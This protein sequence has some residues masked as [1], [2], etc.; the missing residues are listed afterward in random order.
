MAKARQGKPVQ[1]DEQRQRA[2]RG[3]RANERGRDGSAAGEGEPGKL[4][5][6][7]GDSH[8]EGQAALF[9]DGHLH[10]TQ[11]RSLMTRIGRQ[12]GNTYLQRIMEQAAERRRGRALVQRQTDAGLPAGVPPTTEE[13]PAPSTQTEIPV[14]LMTSVDFHSLT[15][16]ALRHRHDLLQQT[17]LQLAQSSPDVQLLREQAT[18]ISR[19][20][21]ERQAEARVREELESFLA[22][23][24]SC[25]G[26]C[27]EDSILSSLC[28][29]S[30]N[31][32]SALKYS[33]I[34][35]NAIP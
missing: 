6:P 18:Q 4:P 11:R 7:S 27:S 2:G 15:D 20:L 32:R 19:V 22:G 28:S 17:L 29:K 12:L 5:A 9:R 8:V 25:C 21:A 23:F 13:R 24:S 26:L 30:M 33:Q 34:A 35:L 31:L 10:S 16:D 1:R 3:D 14:E